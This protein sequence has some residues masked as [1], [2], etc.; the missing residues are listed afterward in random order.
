MV[1]T[2]ATIERSAHEQA[3]AERSQRRGNDEDLVLL[4]EQKMLE[5]VHLRKLLERMN[6]S[7]VT[8]AQA[9]KESEAQGEAQGEAGEEGRQ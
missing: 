8:H 6:R 7:H 3:L 5:E 1:Q 4:W 2:L 9:R